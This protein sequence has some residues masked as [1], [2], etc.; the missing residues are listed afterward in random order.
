MAIVNNVLQ[1]PTGARRSVCRVNLRA[2]G[3]RGGGPVSS[4]GLVN[5]Q[6]GMGTSLDHGE[7]SLFTPTRI[8]WR[9]PLEILGVQSW[10]AR[11]CIDIPKR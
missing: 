3:G 6:T 9:T 5:L 2:Q 1:L 10:V 7:G 11:N 4:G 8:Y